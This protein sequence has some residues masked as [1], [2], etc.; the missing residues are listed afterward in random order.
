MLDA[1]E[2]G[3]SATAPPANGSPL[4]GGVV[5]VE[6]ELDE[7]PVIVPVAPTPATVTVPVGNVPLDMSV[8]VGLDGES[9]PVGSGGESVPGTVVTAGPSL[10]EL[11]AVPPF[12]RTGAVKDATPPPPRGAPFAAGSITFPVGVS[13]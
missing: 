12:N 4:S 11:P 10:E 13:N 2:A 1:E 8:P 5:V 9:V 6:P 3:L 7:V